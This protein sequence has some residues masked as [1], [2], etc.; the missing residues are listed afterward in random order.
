MKPIGQL[1]ADPD[2]PAARAQRLAS[3]A[4]VARLA[5]AA[6]P[7]D[8]PEPRRYR[9][10]LAMQAFREAAVEAICAS[11][12]VA[13]ALAQANDGSTIKP[14]LLFHTI[15]VPYAIEVWRWGQWHPLACD[16]P[17]PPTITR[18]VREKTDRWAAEKEAKGHAQT[19]P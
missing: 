10:R 13:S 7:E 4:H 2:D 17:A 18:E 5:S 6:D 3:A 19:T 9:V 1:L 14:G 8:P 16:P 12:A 11:D 15:Y